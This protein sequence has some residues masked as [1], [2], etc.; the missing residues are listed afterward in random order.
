M[1]N[2]TYKLNNGLEMPVVGL[3]TW[4]ASPDIT[5]TA[6]KAA[7]KCGYRMI[8][9]ANDYGNEVNVGEALKEVFDEG[10]VSRDEL[11]IQSKLWNT[12]HR[13][14]HVKADLM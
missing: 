11:F 5:R 8:D 6:V 4:K 14:E 12:N 10:I 3:G 13:K 9:T 7:I 1:T 2:Q